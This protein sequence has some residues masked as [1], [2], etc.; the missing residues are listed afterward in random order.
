MKILIIEDDNRIANNVKRILEQNGY[1][2]HIEETAEGGMYEAE[3]NRYDVI[4]LDWMLPDDDGLNICKK[5]R[6]K[7]N[8]TP[9][10][11][12]TAK[13]QVDDQVKGLTSGADDYVIKPFLS[14]VFLARINALVRRKNNI[15]LNSII[16]V[17]DLKIYTNTV[18]VMYRDDQIDLAPKE[19]DLLLYLATHK[20][21]VIDRM[22]L[23]E[24]VWGDTVNDFSN[25][26][27]VHIRYLR[28]KLD[29]R[30]QV[31]LIRTVIN[32]GYMICDNLL[33]EKK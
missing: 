6:N 10:L 13:G 12:L 2:V 31:N 3:N 24:E 15:N 33:Q 18:T 17:G 19:Y 28:I 14:D 5:M 25:T 11:M 21:Q 29:L 7:K 4:I 26:V 8:T 22:Q 27:D 16:T 9:I 32:K 23:M 1:E 20:N 30:Y